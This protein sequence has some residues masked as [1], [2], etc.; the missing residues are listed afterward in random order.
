[1]PPRRAIRDVAARAAELFTCFLPVS[2]V[3]QGKHG[4]VE[5]FYGWTVIDVPYCSGDIFGG[6]TQN[7][8]ILAHQ[9]ASAWK[10]QSGYA[11]MDAVMKWTQVG[12][13]GKRQ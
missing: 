8:W 5:R 6:A 1:M 13:A 7:F 10:Q 11:N 12:S 4:A 9:T 2:S 3:M